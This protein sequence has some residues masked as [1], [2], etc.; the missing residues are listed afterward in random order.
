MKYLT[1]TNTGCIDICRNMIASLEKCGVD[2]QNVHIHCLDKN[3]LNILK[4]QNYNVYIWKEL[5]SDLENYQEWSFDPSSQF[6]KIVSWKWKIIKNF[7][8][9]NKEFIFTDTDIFYIKNVEEDLKTYNKNICT[10]CDSPGSLYCTGFMYFK[11]SLE[12]DS[13]INSCANNHV[14]DQIIFNRFVYELNLK[15]KIQ[16][17]PLEKYPNGHIFYKTPIDKQ[18]VM[19]I[20][21]NHMLGIHNKVES[22]KNNGNWLV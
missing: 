6:S 1:Y 19:M 18:N 20:H 8:A 15:E 9:K 12:T 5:S 11:E 22:F 3:S 4:Q 21:N 17:L 10:Q 13:I 2:R 14:D 7:Y 16:L